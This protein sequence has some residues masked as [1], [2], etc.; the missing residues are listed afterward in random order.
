MGNKGPVPTQEL[1]IDDIKIDDEAPSKAAPPSTSSVVNKK[2]KTDVEREQLFGGSSDDVHTPRKKSTQEILTKYKFKGDAAAAAAHAKQK[3]VERQEKLA[4]I[5][6]Q[7]AELES[8]AANFAT[9]AQ[10][11]RKNTETWWWKR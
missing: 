1:T 8:E 9:L 7:S 3:L 6:E 5:T 10:Q 4:R 11:I 2:S